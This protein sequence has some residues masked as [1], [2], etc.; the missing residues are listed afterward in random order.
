[1]PHASHVIISQC[2]MESQRTTST[3]FSLKYENR[4]V[5][6]NIRR[7]MKVCHSFHHLKQVHDRLRGIRR[8]MGGLSV[9][10]DHRL[11]F[12]DRLSQLGLESRH[13]RLFQPRLSSRLQEAALLRSHFRRFRRNSRQMPAVRRRRSGRRRIK[14]GR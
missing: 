1:M 12:L 6:A 5:K 11:V 14:K 10:V 3:Y 9:H 4:R 8:S 2:H 13:L 7:Y